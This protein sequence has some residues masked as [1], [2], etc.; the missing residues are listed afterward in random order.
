MYDILITNGTVIDGTGAK[1]IRVD[2]GI[3]GDTISAVGD[4]TSADA[5]TRL[6]L[7]SSAS[8]DPQS[9]PRSSLCVCPGF[10]DA[11]SHS[12]AY[13]L[14]EPSA[15]NKIYQGIT[16]EVVGNCGAS[17]API[18]DRS[19]LPGDWEDKRFPGEWRTVAE[20]R[21]LLKQVSPAPNAVLLVGHNTLRRSVIGR[22]NREATPD[23]MRLMKER[24]AAGLEDGARGLSTGLIYPPGL[25]APREEIVELARV[26][27]P[28][29]VY[30]SHM[31]SE[32]TKLLEAIEET[33]EVGRQ[34]GARVQVSHLKTAGK[35]S[36]GLIDRAFALLRGAIDEGL[37]AAADRYPY[38][39]GWTELDAALPDW[40][41]EGERSDILERLHNPDTRK[42]I[43]ADVDDC[44]DDARWGNV[45]VGYTHHPDNREYRGKRLTDVAETLG[46]SASEAFLTLIESD[47]LKTGAFFFGMSEENM[48]R[49]LCEPYVMLGTDASLRAPT[50]PLSGGMPHPRTYGSM[51]RFLR[52]VLDEKLMTLTEA[53]RKMTSLPAE[54]F[55]LTNRGVIREGSAAD[56]I[57]FDPDTV[58]DNATYADSHQLASGIS[59]VIV[60]GTLTLD[61]GLLTGR[62]AVRML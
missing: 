57:I 2:V 31:R 3:T 11:H 55:G 47:A 50:G 28:D 29:G 48:R 44:Y 33:L 60:N 16:T 14:I 25:F 27:G 53:I 19:Q 13:L 5:R 62:R 45:V 37:V 32:G 43:L 42:R 21:A 59:S 51:P 8:P 23:E 61:S 38:T 4:L 39:S 9:S 58:R 54:Q 6:D 49:I 46:I 17:C 35:D 56:V 12:D 36:W 10:I 20:Y 1:P 26:V 7:S 41:L 30:S 52:M 18:T 24:L 40:A 22:V 34:S 15:P